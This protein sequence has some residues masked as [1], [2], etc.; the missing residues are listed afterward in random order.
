[1]GRATTLAS[2]DETTTTVFACSTIVQQPITLNL[3]APFDN[4]SMRYATSPT[5]TATTFYTSTCQ[6]MATFA[7]NACGTILKVFL[8]QVIPIVLCA[9]LAT[10]VNIREGLMKAY[11]K[12]VILI[13]RDRL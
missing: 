6:M 7:T 5:A 10:S 9:F 4:A 13:V 8:R 12:W 11:L 2:Q 1:M 3:C